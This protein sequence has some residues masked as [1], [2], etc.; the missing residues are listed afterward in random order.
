VQKVERVRTD[1]QRCVVP[2]DEIPEEL[3]DRLDPV[4]AL[5]DEQPSTVTAVN[6]KLTVC[7]RHGWRATPC[8]GR[9]P[10]PTAVPALA[11]A[12]LAFGSLRSDER[13]SPNSNP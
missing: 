10:V 13:G 12:A 11:A 1:R 8:L 3:V 4:K 7:L 9:D 2:I 6:P 5:A